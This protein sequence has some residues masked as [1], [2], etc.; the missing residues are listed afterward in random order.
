MVEALAFRQCEAQR[1]RPSRGLTASPPVGPCP[2]NP[3]LSTSLWKKAAWVLIGSFDLSPLPT[4]HT[5]DLKS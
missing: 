5:P 2:R 3:S 1:G 4:S